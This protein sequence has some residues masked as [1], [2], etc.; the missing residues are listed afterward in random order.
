[1][2]TALALLFACTPAP[3]PG[4]N[5]TT[6]PTVEPTPTTDTGST[7]TT[8]TTDTF[9]TTTPTT[10]PYDCSVLPAVPVQY[11]T[12][13]GWGTAEDFDFDVE[14]YHVAVLNS[15]LV[16]HDQADAQK[17]ITPNVG[18]FVSGTR[19]LPSG[20][21][22]VANSGTGDLLRVDVATGGQ[23][24]I[25]GGLSYPNGVEV[26]R[27]GY[28]FVAENGVGRIQQVEP[29]TEE[30]WLVAT[31]LD[32]SNGLAF[33]QDESILYVGS[34]GA[35]KVW[36]VPRLGPTEWD[37]PFVLWDTS[38]GDGGFDGIN[39][40]ICGNVYVTEY[41]AGKVWRITPDGLQ[42]DLVIDLSSSWIPNLRWGHGIGG[43][44]TDVLY[45]ADRDQGRLF[46]LQMGIQGRTHVSIPVP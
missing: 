24:S 27:D 25:A 19:V 29:Y 30:R 38:F 12:M 7:V 4:G 22:I 6:I 3:V 15:N 10:E 1:M 41:I 17:I 16:G 36:G 46:A 32:A 8:P 44:E 45:V 5:A 23:T 13:T 43:W 28:A 33:N 14:G 42:G 37:T 40:D 18:S 2:T 35:G 21:W 20:D 9:V 31:G 39:T 11:D 26:S 34:F